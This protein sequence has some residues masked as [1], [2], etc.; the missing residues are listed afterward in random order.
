MSCGYWRQRKEPP[1]QAGRRASPK[2]E[3]QAGVLFAGE[4][5]EGERESVTKVAGA[6]PRM[7]PYERP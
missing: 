5:P 2:L 6:L 7:A 3:K 1:R 4:G